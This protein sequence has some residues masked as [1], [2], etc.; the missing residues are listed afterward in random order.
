[1]KN[2]GSLLVGVLLAWGCARLATPEGGPKDTTPPQVVAHKSTPN[3]I[4]NFRERAIY[5]T[6]D[7]WVVLQEVNSQVL[8]SPPLQRRP[9]VTLKGR[10]VVFRFDK[11]EVLRPNT[12]YTIY[13]GSAVRDLHEGNVAEN[14]RFVFSTGDHIDSAIVAGIVVDAF[15]GDPVKEVSVLL[16]DDLADSAVVLERPYYLTRTDTS[17]QFRFANVRPGVYRCV[18]IEDR[19]RNMR[20]KAEVEPIGF[21]DSFIVVRPTDTL[22]VVPGIYLSTP[23]PSG[24]LLFRNTN[25][26]GSVR[27]GYA[28]LPDTLSLRVAPAAVR[29]LV[30]REQDTLTVWYDNVDSLSWTLLVG[31]DSVAVRALSRTAF[32]KQHRLFWGDERLTPPAGRRSSQAAA[33]SA[34]PPPRIVTVRKGRPLLLPF[35]APISS[36]DTARVSWVV[37]SIPSRVFSLMPD[38]TNPLALRLVFLAEPGQRCTLTLLPGAV[39]DFWGA[40]NA[41]SL[42]RVF[43]IP[44]PKQVSALTIQMEN[45]TP[46]GAY[47]LRLMNGNAVEEERFFVA[48]DALQRETFVDLAPVN[49][50][51][52]LVE[53]SNHNHRWDAG[54]YFSGRQPERVFSK[55]IEALRPNWEVET[56]LSVPTLAPRRRE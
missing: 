6:F 42:V 5:L 27:L 44:H 17:G 14:L 55:N 10:T 36:I 11:E 30:T 48:R 45:L 21:I 2:A 26:Y 18:A 25:Q 35:N 7:E 53:D 46:G 19:D 4:L 49:Y 1:M 40:T 9:E 52:R 20:W 28:Y 34:L 23:A 54:D 22:V 3:G 33:P 31:A 50:T 8:V 41:D 24:R 29:W 12:T 13:F 51:V 38:S 56:T 32:L 47:I 37:D 43:S 39:T 15:S 16:Y